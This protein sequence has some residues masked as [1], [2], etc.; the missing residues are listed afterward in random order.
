MSLKDTLQNDIKAALLGGNRFE[1][2]TLRNLKAAIL[3]E[4]VAMGK[5]DEGLDDAEIEK[6]VAREVKKRRESITVYEE[7]GRPEL[8]Q[9]EK[10]E[11]AVLEKYLPAQLTDEEIRG[12][13]NEVVASMGEVSMQQ[14]GQVI[15]A[16]K[17]KAGNAADGARLAKIVKEELTK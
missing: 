4:E 11:V 6:V 13:V 5:R 1:G 15:G 16:V 2:D 7:N 17:A 3:N 14:M 10:D 8:A 9:T 12:V